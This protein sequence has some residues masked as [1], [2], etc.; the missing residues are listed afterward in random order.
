MENVKNEKGL[1][2][3]W[4]E[5]DEEIKFL[6]C[7]LSE[8]EKEYI[9]NNSKKSKKTWRGDEEETD[10][11]RYFELAILKVIKGWEDLTN[12][13]LIDILDESKFEKKE[14]WEFAFNPD[15][16][17]GPASGKLNIEFNTENLRMLSQNRNLNF[18]KFISH[19]LG[20]VEELRKEEL[21]AKLKN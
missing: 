7:E 4:C 20:Q 6:I 13:G 17:T 1:Y 10:V 11:I 3:M 5:W 12:N 21:R 15:D 19:F 9:N 16:I 8:K 14:G 2:E 18:I